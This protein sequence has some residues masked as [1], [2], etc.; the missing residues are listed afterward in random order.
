MKLRFKL[1]VLL[2]IICISIV[3]LLSSNFFRISNIIVEGN[4]NVSKEEIIRLSSIYYGQNIFQ[5]NKK[6]SMRNILQN[7]YSEYIKIS[8]RLPRTVTI[9]IIER[10]PIA[11]V[12]YVGSY[13]SIDKNGIILEVNTKISKKDIPIIQGLK[14]NNFKIGDKLNLEDKQQFDTTVNIINA[15]NKAEFVNEISGIIMEDI[16]NLKMTTRKGITILLGN[17]NNIEYK[18]SF[19]KTMYD[20]ASQKYLKGTID[21]VHYGNPVF[22]P[23]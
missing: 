20:D 1:A 19:A 17:D 8:R 16:E 3:F 7:P 12:P 21:I 14:F 5:I 4:N 6:K 2:F 11:L 23:E 22:S 9:D 10:K 15:V 13:L 18:V